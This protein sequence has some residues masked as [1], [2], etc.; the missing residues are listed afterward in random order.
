LKRNVR[1]IYVTAFKERRSTTTNENNVTWEVR[2]N[3]Y[4]EL[5]AKRTNLNSTDFAFVSVSGNIST[6]SSG[7]FE[8]VSNFWAANDEVSTTTKC[9]S[10]DLSRYIIDGFNE[11]L[12]PF[13]NGTGE[14]R[15]RSLSTNFSTSSTIN[16]KTWRARPVVFTSGSTLKKVFKDF[17]GELYQLPPVRSAVKRTLRTRMVF[18]SKLIEMKGRRAL[19]R[20]DCEAGTY[21]R[22]YCHDI[23]EALGVGAHMAQ[24]RRTRTGAFLE[25]DAITMHRL[26]DALVYWREHEEEDPLRER[27]II[28]SRL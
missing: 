1:S 4:V 20:I 19:F 21:I 24:L 10:V 3:H 2:I 16:K 9:L 22:T 7:E 13:R 27:Q 8:D 25:K 26:K 14:I 12:I 5:T 17:K 15:S 18:D 6:E 23:G 11:G 28:R